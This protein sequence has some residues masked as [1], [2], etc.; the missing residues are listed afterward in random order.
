MFLFPIDTVF[1]S[2]DVGIQ[3]EHKCIA[4]PERVGGTARHP[5]CNRVVC[6]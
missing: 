3:P 5:R 6:D 4:I 1:M 2:G